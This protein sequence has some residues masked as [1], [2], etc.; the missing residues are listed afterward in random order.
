MIH[1]N[2]RTS[3]EDLKSSL[4]GRHKEIW[5]AFSS[6]DGALRDRQV[7]DILNLPDMNSVRPRITELINRGFLMEV[8]SEKCPI[9]G[10][11]VRRCTKYRGP[12]VHP[13]VY[14]N[15]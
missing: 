3:W 10:K 12:N 14:L 6:T 1:K 11:K 5:K 13:Q 15:I 8:D 4:K 7:K 9:T 2:S